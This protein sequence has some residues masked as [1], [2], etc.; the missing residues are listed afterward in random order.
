LEVQ[1]G[2][3]AGAAGFQQHGAHQAGSTPPSRRTCA[4]PTWASCGRR[5]LEVRE[6]G[7]GEEAQ[8]GM[9]RVNDEVPGGPD[10]GAL[11]RA[12]KLRRG[13]ESKGGREGAENKK[14]GRRK[15]G[16]CGSIHCCSC[17]CCLVTI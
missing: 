14:G 10:G 4:A 17:D 16:S 5:K 15:G 2:L 6:R 7:A 8:G 9:D 12:R 13:A 3:H 1:G 11:W